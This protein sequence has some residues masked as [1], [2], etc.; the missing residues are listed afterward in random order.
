MDRLSNYAASSTEVSLMHLFK[1]LSFHV[2][3]I[4]FMPQVLPEFLQVEAF[5][6]L[7][8]AISRVSPISFSLLILLC[9]FW[10]NHRKRCADKVMDN[11]GTKCDGVFQMLF[12][13]II[14]I[15]L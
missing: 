12:S 6:K 2:L 4:S 7:S 9:L 13:V 10:G 8:T 14:N 5:A 3:L 11:E 15:Y 1:K